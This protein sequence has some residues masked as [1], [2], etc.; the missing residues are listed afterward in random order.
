[1]QTLWQVLGLMARHGALLQLRGPP[2]PLSSVRGSAPASAKA[3]AP[4]TAGAAVELADVLT[5][6]FELPACKAA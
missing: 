6:C 1:M 3:A 2:T 4:D 5:V